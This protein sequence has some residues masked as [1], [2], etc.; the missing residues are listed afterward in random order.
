MLWGALLVSAALGSGCDSLSLRTVDRLQP[1]ALV[2]EH[3]W[4]AEFE[5]SPGYWDLGGRQRGRPVELPAVV[6]AGL[7]DG[8]L[9]ALDRASGRQVWTFRPSDS[10]Q[11]EAITAPAVFGE[12]ILFVGGV[13]GRLYALDPRDGSEVWRYD[14]GGP[15][16]SAA[17]VADG[18]VVVANAL[19]R[20][21]ALDAR[22]GTFL[23]RQERAKPTDYTMLGHTAPAIRDGLVYV[24][25]SDGQ[26]MAYTLSDGTLKWGRDLSG[27]AARFPDVDATPLLTSDGALFASSFAGGLYRLDAASNEVIWRRSDIEGAST[28]TRV[29]AVLYVKSRAGLHAID[30]ATGEDLWLYPLSADLVSSEPVVGRRHIYVSIARR[31]VLVVERSSGRLVSL[32]DPG[33]GVSSA[34]ELSQGR[35][36]VL[37]NGG[38][39]F[40]WATDDAPLGESPFRPARASR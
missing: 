30:A 33:T 10:A 21:H 34:P 9:V 39:V 36:Y 23:W 5:A 25:F 35:L 7:Q 24:G 1:A 6:V 3:V 2:L 20:V 13:D 22:R 38:T 8:R 14:T 16:E 31:G 27:G 11:S 12:G 15:I 19:N 4:A 40:S 26:L 28:A 29:D 32:I 37:S 17:A 18:V